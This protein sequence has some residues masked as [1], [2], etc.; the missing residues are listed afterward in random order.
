MTDDKITV[1]TQTTAERE[2][3]KIELWEKCQPY[4]KEGYTLRKAVAKVKGTKLPP[5][6]RLAWFRD[7]RRYAWSQ[8]YKGQ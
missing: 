3:E 4:I 2:Q 5:S 1:I 6:S 8:G 7:L